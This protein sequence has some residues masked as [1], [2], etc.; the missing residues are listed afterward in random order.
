MSKALDEAIADIREYRDRVEEADPRLVWAQTALH[1][2]PG[3]VFWTVK[4][5]GMVSLSVGAGFDD[6][7]I[8]PGQAEDTH[9]S[10]WTTTAN[11]LVEQVR[12]FGKVCRAVY[13]DEGPAAGLYFITSGV[14]THG[15]DATFMTLHLDAADGWRSLLQGEP[16]AAHS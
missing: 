10:A 16:Y 7:D 9:I 4:P 8:E 11:K 6:M 13:E 2:L 15:G 3:V 14:L 5:D 1:H 12:A